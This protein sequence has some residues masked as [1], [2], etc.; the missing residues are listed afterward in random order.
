MPQPTNPD[1]ERAMQSV[2]EATPKAEADPTRPVYHF[3]P[4]A[5]WMNDPNGTIYHNG[6]YHLFY[7]HNPY[8]D[9]WAHM[10]WGHARSKDLLRWEHLPIGLWPSLELG[11]GHCFS[12]C[13][14]I[15]PN[16]QPMLIYSKVA[17][18]E[19]DRK[20]EDNEQWLAL[21][22]SD[23]LTWE[24][25][26][27][28]P[29]LGPG[30]Q[31]APHFKSGWRDP[32]VFQ[33][34]GRNFLVLGAETDETQEVAL[35]EAEDES[36]LR[37]TYRGPLVHTPAKER[38]FYE[39]PNFIN[40]GEKWALLTS[41]YNL[42]DYVVGTFDVDSLT[43]TPETKG[44]ID[45]GLGYTDHM[46]KTGEQPNWYA[47]NTLYDPEGRCILLGWLRGF[48]PNRGWNGTLALPRVMTLGPDNRPRIVPI[49]ELSDLRTKQLTSQ[50]NIVVNGTHK[51]EGVQG[52][53]LEL[54]VEMDM[55]TAQKVGLKVRCDDNGEQ[56]VSIDYNGQNLNVAGTVVPFELSKEESALELHI[57]ID[58][59]VIEVFVNQGRAC[60][61]RV[62][63]PP[64]DHLSVVLF[65]SGGDANISMLDVWA[66][67]RIW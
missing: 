46:A 58:K 9:A 61:T 23:W 42:V 43:F 65:A 29:L 2:G 34:E 48:A 32:Y 25:W 30:G 38:F 63:Y 1:I 12:G 59:S 55:G 19:K 51:L 41:P 27:G 40:L 67:G 5:N 20:P 53:T 14:A 22:S 49:P 26:Q 52:D 56:G 47:S 28:N 33:A 62:V 4:P 39:C 50:S 35:Y 8:G 13:A 7:Q 21:G 45:Y 36:L 60:V 44:I 6:Y 18:F 3:R 37:W 10:H 57:F 24:K 64:V 66:V 31:G 15:G 11:E 17:P 54:K 16:D